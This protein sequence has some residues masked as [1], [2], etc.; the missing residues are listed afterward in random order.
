MLQSAKSRFRERLPGVFD[1]QAASAGEVVAMIS[2][3]GNQDEEEED[4]DED[5]E[6]FM[7]L[8]CYDYH[9]PSRCCCRRCRYH[10]VIMRCLLCYARHRYIYFVP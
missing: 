10:C 9:H 5:V 8:H 1:I 7:R 3:K 4:D 2:G 6:V